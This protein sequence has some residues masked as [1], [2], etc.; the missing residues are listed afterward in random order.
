VAGVRVTFEPS[1]GSQLV[2]V[3][4]VT[5][6]DGRAGAAWR[7]LV[8]GQ[9]SL[10]ITAHRAIGDPLRAMVTA[11]VENGSGAAPDRANSARQFADAEAMFAAMT[12][13][14]AEPAPQAQQASSGY[15]AF[16]ASARQAAGVEPTEAER[17]ATPAA[18][19]PVQG[20]ASINGMQ[21][22][23]E[24]AIARRYAFTGKV[25]QRAFYDWVKKQCD[26]RQIAGYVGRGQTR[27]DVEVLAQGTPGAI[28]QLETTFNVGP[29][30]PVRIDKWVSSDVELTAV[31]GFAIKE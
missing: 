2:A 10:V 23:A 7:L 13:S 3:E 14:H 5:D 20:S 1:T 6:G 18:S 15:A 16:A 27:T 19:P 24:V 31:E 8:A 22:A 29:G 30:E 17:E 12:S 4:G 28:Q 26:V 11:R 21:A 25:Q 9:Q